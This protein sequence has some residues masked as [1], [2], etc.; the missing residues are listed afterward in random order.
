VLG[1]KDEALKELQEAFEKHFPAEFAAGDTE[2][3]NIQSAPAF[4][5]LIGKY[6]TPKK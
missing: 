3:E 2:L 5:A 6:S 1:R 4:R